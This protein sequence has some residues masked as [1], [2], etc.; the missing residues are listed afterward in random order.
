MQDAIP[1]IQLSGGQNVHF[2]HLKK[3][4][5]FNLLINIFVRDIE[6][7]RGVIETP[8]VFGMHIQELS[9]V[10]LAASSSEVRTLITKNLER[11]QSGASKVR[12]HIRTQKRRVWKLLRPQS[13]SFKSFYF[14]VY[15]ARVCIEC[16]YEYPLH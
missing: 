9:F 12:M 15:V 7:S 16:N 14:T 2:V 3:I 4:E 1:L 13:Y 8:R 5:H 6:Q 11:I 10:V